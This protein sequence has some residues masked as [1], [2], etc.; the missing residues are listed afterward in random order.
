[1]ELGDS[2]AI[3][4]MRDAEPAQRAGQELELTSNVGEYEPTAWERMNWNVGL[5]DKGGLGCWG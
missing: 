5:E 1:M 3:T 2:L 4:A